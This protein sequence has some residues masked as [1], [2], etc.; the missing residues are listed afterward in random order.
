MVA[1]DDTGTYWVS[2]SGPPEGDRIV[3]YGA[4]E[5]H[6]NAI[7]RHENGRQER[8]V[9]LDLFSAACT[10]TQPGM[11][12]T[13]SVAIV[14]V[15]M[16]ACSLEAVPDQGSAIEESVL[17]EEVEAAVWAF[18]AAD[19][20]MDAEG[21]IA[22]LWPDYYM[23]GDGQRIGYEDVVRGSREFMGGLELFATEWRDLRITPLGSDAAVS[24]FQF[25]DSIITKSG[26]LMRSQGPTTFVWVRR[27]GEWRLVYADA[28]HYPIDP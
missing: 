17:R 25:R 23:L 4:D 12:R 26:Q 14:T 24:S 21:V 15:V 22:L 16:C 7:H 20:A 10:V 5:D 18:H 1:M 28:D 6:R 13:V 27:D 8:D 9:F 19:T 3:M 11:R 2:A